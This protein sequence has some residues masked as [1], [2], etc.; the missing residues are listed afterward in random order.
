MTAQVK[1]LPKKLVEVKGIAPRCM[2]H[3]CK[4]DAVIDKDFQAPLVACPEGYK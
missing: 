1:S 3:C 2:S 4:E